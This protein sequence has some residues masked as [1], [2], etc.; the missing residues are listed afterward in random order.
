[1][2]FALKKRIFSA[3]GMTAVFLGAVAS[4][5]QGLSLLLLS[6][7]PF[8]L[9][10]WRSMCRLPLHTFFLMGIFLSALVVLFFL[11]PCCVYWAK[12]FAVLGVLGFFM[13]SLFEKKFWWAF[14]GLAYLGAFLFSGLW[15]LN[16]WGGVKVL[17]WLVSLTVTSDV[18]AY[19]GGR[20]FK[21]PKLALSISPSKTWSGFFTGVISCGVL[22][23]IWQ[24]IVYHNI[25]VTLLI[26]LSAFLGF[27][28]AMGD[29]LESKIKRIHQVKDSGAFLPGH[30]G[31]LDR[32]DSLILVL[33]I[34]MMLIHFFP[35]HFSVFFE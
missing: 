27:V 25:S 2:E 28:G 32:L 35:S 8:L 15:L 23:L 10:E 21:G 1:M 26:S 24:K 20:T 17:F 19:F 3:L 33:P 29:L 4:G 22:G 34:L 5:V 6:T 16:Q 11:R 18:M 9:W 31:F 7:L 14:F 30:G 12:W 13:G